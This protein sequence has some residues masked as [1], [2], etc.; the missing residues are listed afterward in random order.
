MADTAVVFLAHQFSAA[1]AAR[2]ERL[3]RETWGEADCHLLLHDDGGAVRAGWQDFL[4]GIGAAQALHLFRPDELAAELGLPLFG[5]KGLLGNVHFPLLRFARTAPHRR[6]WQVE[7][8]VEYRGTW[9]DLLRGFAAVEASLLASHLHRRA[10][11]PGWY[12]WASA[13]APPGLQLPASAWRKAFF[14]VCRFDRRAL[15]AIEAAHRAGWHAHFEALIPTALAVAGVEAQD[16]LDHLP[17]YGSGLQ[18][19]DE[20]DESMATIRWRPEVT[21]EEFATRGVGPLL[22]HP[23]KQGWW[24][25]GA[26]LVSA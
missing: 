22:F 12:W 14:P 26:A 3:R 19:P 1:I 7:S 8:D 13:T 5:G 24:F 25:D 4:E 20:P 23:V 18:D 6:F 2:F 16:L 21:R 15:A 9:G 17:C 10:Q 11:W